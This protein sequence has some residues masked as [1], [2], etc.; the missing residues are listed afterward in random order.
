M[1]GGEGC[2]APGHDDGVLAECGGE[3]VILFST[4]FI[5]SQNSNKLRQVK[6]V[7]T[8]INKTEQFTFQVE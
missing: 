4:H 3:G 6:N 5:V 2:E 1:L 8:V 7:F